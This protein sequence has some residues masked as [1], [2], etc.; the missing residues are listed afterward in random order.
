MKGP[1]YWTL[2]QLRKTEMSDMSLKSAVI[3]MVDTKF[4]VR[5]HLLSKNVFLLMS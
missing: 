4:E 5:Y 1:H 2:T 3:K